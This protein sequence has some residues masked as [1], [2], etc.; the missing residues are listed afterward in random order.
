MRLGTWSWK[1]CFTKAMR[2]MHNTRICLLNTGGLRGSWT[3]TSLGKLMNDDDMLKDRGENRD[4]FVA[5]AQCVVPCLRPLSS[6]SRPKSTEHC[7]TGDIVVGLSTGF[8]SS[9]STCRVICA[10]RCDFCSGHGRRGP[11]RTF[12][13]QCGGCSS[14]PK[15]PRGVAVPQTASP[16]RQLTMDVRWLPAWEEDVRIKSV[17]SVHEASNLQDIYPFFETETSGVL[18]RQ[19]RHW[20]RAYV[21]P[22]W[23]KVD[24]SRTNLGET[25]Q[26]ALEANGAQSLDISGEAHEQDGRVEVLRRNFEN[27]LLRVLAQIRPSMKSEW[28]ECVVR[29]TEAQNSSIR[30]CGC[31]ETY[32]KPQQFCVR[33]MQPRTSRTSRSNIGLM[34]IWTRME[35]R[36]V[37]S[38]GPTL[39][40][41][42]NRPSGGA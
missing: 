21:R 22:R 1:T 12:F 5:N 26:R 33:K 19:Y 31:S 23:V 35:R 38:N 24:A 6:R 34:E 16:L 40:F 15:I 27:L 32:N 2:G 14:A 10:R 13:D 30:R 37:H 42:K 41:L 36:R 8:A 3:P 39:R 28:L 20:R 17:N 7:N 4:G 29:T 11:A 18:L 9:M 25:P